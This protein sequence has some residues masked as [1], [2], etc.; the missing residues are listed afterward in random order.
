M[1]EPD[2]SFFEIDPF[3]L[4]ESLGQSLYFQD[5]RE[6]EAIPIVDDA[7]ATLR[8]ARGEINQDFAFAIA[9]KASLADQFGNFDEAEADYARAAEIYR[10]I[11]G[12]DHQSV[13]I[14]LAN[15]G[16][17]AMHKKDY[18]RAEGFFR[19]VIRRYGRI[20]P[21]DNEN[22]GIAR[23]KLG[24]CLL[25]EKRYQDAEKESLA[26][27]QIVAKQASPSIDFLRGAR[28]DLIAIYLALGESDKAEKFRAEAVAEKASRK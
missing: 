23:I 4:A 12:D 15:V 28:S 21:A 1:A 26:G 25:R 8:N 18:V 5:G 13:V 7:L 2:D 24:R 10:A 6:K 3:K 17:I 9:L 19:D 20:L 11:R 16:S 27:Y 22:V 14:E